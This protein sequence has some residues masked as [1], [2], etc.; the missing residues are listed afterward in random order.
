ME[1]PTERRDRVA[2]LVRARWPNPLPPN[3]FTNTI[4][5]IIRSGGM[6][7]T[8]S[9]KPMDLEDVVE[10]IDALTEMHLDVSFMLWSTEKD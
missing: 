5:D 4:L 10:A 6:N 7:V 1:S 8:H 2:A 3:V 9:K